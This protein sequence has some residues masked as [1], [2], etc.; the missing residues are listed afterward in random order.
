MVSAATTVSIDVLPIFGPAPPTSDPI[1][2]NDSDDDGQEDEDE[3]DADLTVPAA[4][5]VTKAVVEQ[6]AKTRRVDQE[7]TT[8]ASILVGLHELSGGSIQPNRVVI[9]A[10]VNPVVQVDN[11]RL[12]R[13]ALIRP[14]SVSSSEATRLNTHRLW[15]DLNS[16]SQEM[17]QGYELR[18]LV[19][20]TSI[21][22]TGAMSAGFVI[23][24]IRAGYAATMLSSSLPAWASIDPIPVLDSEAL[25]LQQRTR[26]KSQAGETLLDIVKHAT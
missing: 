8:E 19:V 18:D 15:S 14:E 20:G 7:P 22:A 17:T 11:P 13:P 23:W 9:E 1:D 16:M 24:T 3:N 12:P 10:I 6:D 25:A 26:G 21:I 5:P 4:P 2:S